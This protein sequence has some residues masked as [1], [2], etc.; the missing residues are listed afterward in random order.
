[1]TEMKYALYVYGINADRLP[2]DSDRRL[3]DTDFTK[4]VERR[5]AIEEANRQRQAASNIIQFPTRNDVV[6]GRGRPY[7]E[8]PGNKRLRQL[9]DQY[10][11]SYEASSKFGKTDIVIK[12]LQIITTLGG[13]F[14]KRES[15]PS[16]DDQKKAATSPATS[17]LASSS[18]RRSDDDDDDGDDRDDERKKSS[19][20]GHDGEYD[21]ESSA[22]S[23]ALVSSW[24]E[25]DATTAHRKVS[26]L[27]NTKKHVLSSKAK[28]SGND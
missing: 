12:V 27:F 20:S 4:Q 13:K 26:N 24:V 21:E 6:L 18:R 10:Q 16:D 3:N 19:G 2:L 28:A 7:Q 14:L 11:E 5:K 17:S 25:V 8:F 15:R 23:T 9:V 22:T 1:M